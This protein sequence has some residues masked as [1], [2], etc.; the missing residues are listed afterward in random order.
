L[1][2]GSRAPLLAEDLDDPLHGFAEDDPILLDDGA[3]KARREAL[4]QPKRPEPGLVAGEKVDV[5]VLGDPESR[6]EVVL[7]IHHD[8]VVRGPFT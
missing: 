2:P 6:A 4:V 1:G 8:E 3:F 5:L 7:E